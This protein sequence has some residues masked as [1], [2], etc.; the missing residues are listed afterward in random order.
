MQFKPMTY[1]ENV[2]MVKESKCVLD[3]VYSKQT[4]LSMRAYESMAAHRKY[5]TNNA[6]VKNYDFYNPSNILVVDAQKPA[7][8]KEFIDSP[9]EPVDENVMYKYS[10][11]G[12]IDEVFQNV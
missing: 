5:I 9:F 1:L 2:E 3:F 4:G 7:I 8:P 10:I 12:F 6:E 11:K